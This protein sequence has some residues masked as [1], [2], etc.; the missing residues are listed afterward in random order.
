MDA[1]KLLARS[2][3]LQKSHAKEV[4]PVPSAG[5]GSSDLRPSTRA[6]HEERNKGTK[7]KRTPS[8]AHSSETALQHGHSS[9]ALKAESMIEDPSLRTHVIS[10]GKDGGDPSSMGETERRRIL[11]LHKLKTMAYQRK[12]RRKSK[13]PTSN[14]ALATE[15]IVTPIIPQPLLSFADLRPL[16]SISKR[17]SENL[18]EQGYRE[19]TAVQAG[20]L[21]VLLGDDAARG[22][23]DRKERRVTEKAEPHVDLI[24]VAPTGSGKTLAFMVPLIHQLI[25]YRHT[26]SKADQVDRVRAVILAPTHELVDQI[27]NEGRKLASNTGIRVSAL[28]KGTAVHQSHMP[29]SNDHGDDF[30]NGDDRETAS[31]I[32]KSDIIVSTPSLL[33]RSLHVSPE[34]DLANEQL[35]DIRHL[36]LD[37]ADVLLDPLFRADTLGV[38]HA[39]SNPSLQTSLWSATIGSSIETLAKEQIWQRRQDLHLSNS[40]HHIIRL[41]VGLKDSAVSNISHRM[42]FTGSEQ[43]KLMAMR[44]LLHPI[45]SEQEKPLRPPFLVFTQTIARANAL[46]SELMYDIPIE[47]GG[48]SRMAVL[49]A[50]LSDT[51]RSTIMTGFRKGEIWVL[52]TTDLLSRGVDFKG[53]NGVVNYDIPNTGAAYV[54]RA[55]RTGRAGREGGVAVTL[56]TKE[57]IP[58]VKNI[59]NVIAA[60]KKGEGKSGNAARDTGDDTS[61]SDLQAWLLDALPKVSK[62]TKSELKRRGVAAR[63]TIHDPNGEGSEKLARKMRISSKSGYDRQ[64]ENRRRGAVRASGRDGNRRDGGDDGRGDS[65]GEA[66]RGEESGWEG[67]GD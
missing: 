24:T 10:R 51:A 2:T 41:V 4:K 56:Y 31:S 7:R 11:K 12:V 26:V 13:R 65:D 5:G 47:A 57:D 30:E 52:I 42:V 6:N 49:H 67:I 20:V 55:G 46:H 39:C 44:Q 28:R 37:E 48:S 54:H 29:Q 66:R 32:V 8:G 14:E 25:A 34:K 63:R 59:A 19:P 50:D 61:G 27:V 9:E 53:V 23:I 33:L 3:N 40:S 62:K 22:I 45:P 60:S 15:D 35:P 36:I 18:A 58:Y 21:P 43:G 64:L 38:W 17:L 16:Y 1:F